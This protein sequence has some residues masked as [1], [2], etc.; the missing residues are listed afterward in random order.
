MATL[1]TPFQKP[2]HTGFP[3]Q[4]TAIAGFFPIGYLDGVSVLL[5]P[6]P[7]AMLRTLRLSL[8]L[9][10]L[11]PAAV[12]QTTLIEPHFAFSPE[13]SYNPAVPSPA[14][15]LGYELG[16]RYTLYAHVV[17]YLQALAAASDRVT[18]H[19]YG[20]TYEGRPLY[21]LVVTAP[22]NH[23]R[24]DE[25]RQ[26]NLRLADPADT[27]ADA[28]V[29]TQPVIPW[30]SYNVHGNEGSST[31]AAMQVAYRLAA[32]TDD[33]TRSLLEQAVV[34]LDPCIN[35]DG[36]DRYVYWY[37]SMHNTI[38]N[39]NEYDLE[40]DEPW[41]GGRTNHY[42]FDLNRDWT[43][44]VHPES[45]GRIAAYQQWLPQ[46]HM[47]Y[48]EQGFNSN[49]FTMPGQAPRNLNLPDQY[50]RWAETFGRANARAFDQHQINYFTREAFD[51][52]YPGYG[53]SYPSN[54]GGIGMLSEQ[55]GHSRGGRAVKTN[56]DYVL[57]LRQRIFDHY[58]TSM[59]VLET[60]VQNREALLGYF[61]T[62][63][64]PLANKRR[65]AAYLL[66]DDG[67]AGYAYDVV[68]ILLKH[69]VRV[70]RAAEPF[71]V[72][73]AR[74]YW[75][76]RAASRTFEA[77]TFL[78]STDQARH[79]LIN[80]LLQR[81]MA[82]EDSVMYDMAT[83]SAPL[84]YNLDAA[85][86]TTKPSARTTV[87]SQAPKPASGLTNAAAQYAYV[88]DWKQRNAP[89]ALV[90]L[91]E[92]GYRV[93][94]ARK[95][96]GDSA[97]TF[98]RGSLIVLLG[99]N[100]DKA[101]TAAADMQRIAE[102]AGVAIIGMDSGRMAEGI[103]LASNDSRPLKQPKVAMLVDEPF[104]SYTAGQLWHLFEQGTGFGISRIRADELSRLKLSDYDVLL[105]PGAGNLSEVIDSTQVARIQAWVR[106]G[107]TL[108]A[109]EGSALF[110]T[111][112]RSKLTSVALV[113][114]AKEDN[115]DK[116][117]EVNPSF[118]TAYEARQDSS[119]L[120]RIPGSAL[121]AMLDVSNPLAFGL[122]EHLYSLKFNDDA[123]EPSDQLQ[124]VGYYDQ[125]A[126]TVLASGYA[127]PK[128][129]RKLAG[130]AFAAVQTIGQG[131]VV[132]LVDN[133]QYRMF[134]VGPARLMQNAV[135]LLPGM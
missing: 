38:V 92:A 59:A 43:W 97:H 101:R 90:Q 124:T 87:L 79:V 62:F 126:A 132:F 54:L 41:P 60:S 82:I 21:Y 46:V 74:S 44:L 45:Q 116:A 131:R 127:A 26:N 130:K 78:I 81:E 33:A 91:W 9:L 48:H 110:L 69:G 13:V 76:G 113:K 63:F 65:A 67:G 75:D 31:E 118:Y 77:G 34:I 99:R 117:P 7:A 120:D 6:F 108:V 55:G 4:K 84:A 58:T 85:W 94:A 57:T 2:V 73:D 27:G 19:E 47:D 3:F 70:E 129:R 53:S 68:N 37:T 52:F 111:K 15:F 50:D 96:F 18:L 121:R 42:W 133:T 14:A 8:L 23:A 22:S 125:D 28:L 10:L 88:V 49:Y 64:S 71:T 11:A 72:R 109:T 114:D 35:P 102:S 123:L 115:K 51:F 122:P 134:W 61:R 25:I 30:L 103:D 106:E 112:D 86:T 119:G 24:I 100:R 98:S 93:R 107:G 16:E 105:L 40:H 89:R 36:R 12:A 128:H 29:A 80:T 104:S 39:T 135:L 32:G 66:A 5:H 20:R 95:T 1:T 83:W 56:D 17:S